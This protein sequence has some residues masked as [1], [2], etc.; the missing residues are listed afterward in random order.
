MKPV[1]LA[2]C[3]FLVAASPDVV[4]QQAHGQA[5]YRGPSTEQ[6]VLTPVQKARLAETDALQIAIVKKDLDTVRRLIARGLKVDFN[7][8]EAYRGRS[9]ESPLTMAIGRGHVE[10]AR[11]LL[12]AGADPNR[13]D[14]FGTLAIHRARSDQAVALLRRYGADINSAD[15]TSLAGR[16]P[17]QAIWD[18]IDRA[19]DAETVK[20]LIEKGADPS[21]IFG[22][23]TL[24]ERALF[25]KRWSIA[26]QLADG[27]ANLQPP[28]GAECAATRRE[29][30]SIDAARLATMDPPTLAHLKMRGLDLD[31]VAASGLSALTSLLLEPPAMRVAA[32]SPDGR[33]GATLDPPAELP[34]IRALL[35][36]RADPNRRFRNY[37]PLMIAVVAPQKPPALADALVEFG[38]RVEFDYTIAAPS[39]DKPAAAFTLPASAATAI[40]ILA[41]P[42]VRDEGGVL[43]GRTIGPLSWLVLY[44]RADLAA[45]ILERERT[46]AASDRFLLYFASMLG[47]WPFVIS[48]LPHVREVDA[49]DRAGVTPLLLA[50]DDGRVDAV[51][52]LIAAGANVNARSDRGWPPLWETP[53][54][55]WFMG[56]PPS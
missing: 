54:S 35:E 55:I 52:A 11:L 24:L 46:T 18:V 44:R 48:V 37:T 13:R 33:I 12:D 21:A 8:D 50:A 4:A 17:T 3:M 56:H 5:G 23:E 51:K 7:F 16:S 29:C 10:I 20:L 9:S 19:D 31:R 6:P 14:G 36:Q 38:G 47:E 25:R 53:R 40:A 42:P 49:A 43:R 30:H 2:A 41:E 45:R 22:R 26:R 34:R 1:V 28:D 27:G 39:R 15:T 32:V